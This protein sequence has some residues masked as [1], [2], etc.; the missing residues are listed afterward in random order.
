MHRT[1]RMPRTTFPMLM[2]SLTLGGV[3]PL[4]AR[5]GDDFTLPVRRDG[6]LVVQ[7]PPGPAAKPAQSTTGVKSLVLTVGSSQ[8]VQMKDKKQI[9]EAINTKANVAVVAEFPNDPTSVS[10]TGKEPGVTRLTLRGADNSEEVYDVTVEFDIEF[11]RSLLIRAVPTASLN[12]IPAASGAVIIGGTVQ[13]AEDTDII[14]RAAGSVLGGVDRVINAMQ[15]GG[16]QQVQLDAVVALVSRSE[17]RRMSFDFQLNQ[18]S[19]TIAGLTG[20]GLFVPSGS[21]LSF[22]GRGLATTG[23]PNGAPPNLFLAVAGD[24]TQFFG[25]LQALRDEN[26]AKILAQPKVVALSGRSALLL[27]GGEQAVPEAAGLGSISVRFEPFGTKLNILPIVLGNGKIY[28]EVEPEVSFLDPTTGTSINGTTVDGRLTQRVHTSVEI[29]DGQTLAIGGLIQNQV[30]GKTTKFPVLGD[31]PFVGVFFSTKS[32]EERETELVVLVTPHVVDPM[33]CDQLPKYLPGQ[34]TRTPDDFELF[35]EGILEAPR[36]HRE[37]FPDKRYKAAYLNS[38]TASVYPCAGDGNGSGSRCGNGGCVQSALPG[39]AAMDSKAPAVKP[40]A[41]LQ[42]DGSNKALGLATVPVETSA[43]STP[44][45]NSGTAGS[46]G[47]SPLSP[48]A[49]AKE[50]KPFVLPSVSGT[51]GKGEMK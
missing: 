20:Q 4:A 37:V 47:T 45:A 46:Q 26:L 36:G 14:L 13:R 25:L 22:P 16:V 24:R 8:R 41:K 49:A 32:Y 9:K 50:T 34:E 33:A 27:S 12:L 35:L 15:V 19:V 39:G 38:P 48:D 44:E 43:T 2:L 11:L 29:E 10:I 28:L 31:L 30:T 40:M 51:P 42:M 1:H 17:L 7:Q 23:N 21:M 3:T 6:D 18:P 5:A